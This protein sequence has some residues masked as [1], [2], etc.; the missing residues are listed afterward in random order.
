MTLSAAPG[1][2]LTRLTGHFAELAAFLDA[3]SDWRRRPVLAESAGPG[4]DPLPSLRHVLALFE[5][6]RPNLLA[7]TGL[8]AHRGGLRRYGD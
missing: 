1:T 5:T 3:C 4:K 7:A 2:A 6:E 8:A